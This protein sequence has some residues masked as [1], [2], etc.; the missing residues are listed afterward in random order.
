MNHY[1]VISIVKKVGSETTQNNYGVS[2]IANMPD[3]NLG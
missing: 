1:N 2:P 3:A